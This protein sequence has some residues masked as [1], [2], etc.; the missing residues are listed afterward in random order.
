MIMKNLFKILFCLTTSFVVAIPCLFCSGTTVRDLAGREVTVPIPSREI[1]C[2]GAGCLRLATYL[3]CQDS[4]AAVD[5]METKGMIIDARPYAVANPHYKQLPVFGE[6]R[7]RDNLERI[8]TL[9]SQPSVIFKTCADRG[10]NADSLMA[11]TGIPVVVLEYGNLTW[12]RQSL[13]K[14]LTLMGKI[15]GTIHRAQRVIDFFNELETDLKRRTESIPPGDR[16]ACYIGGIGGSGPH[17]MPSTETAFEPFLFTYSENVASSARTKGKRS[18][19]SVSKEQI[20]VWDP[21]VIFLD[22]STLLVTSVDSALHQLRN[23][24]AYSVL[25]AV[26]NGNVYGLFPYNSY[27]HNFGS[28]Y[29]NAYFVGKILYPQ[30]FTDIDP[31]KKAEAISTFLNGGPSYGILKDQFRGLPFS[32]IKVQK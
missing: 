24:P 1:L 32:R 22:V 30:R 4:V 15:T 28:T 7:G 11:K 23:D 13:V 5:T 6:L 21:D 14:S 27:H 17:G 18:K 25:K 26:K 2:S 3:G 16:P 20:M 31:M 29:S 9:P 10:E 12:D 19:A 8:V